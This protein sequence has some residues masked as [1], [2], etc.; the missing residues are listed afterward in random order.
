MTHHLNIYFALTRS[1][2]VRSKPRKTALL[3]SLFI[4][5]PRNVI[6]TYAIVYGIA[7][8]AANPISPTANA[9]SI[10]LATRS[11][12]DIGFAFLARGSDTPEFP[13]ASRLGLIGK[14][15]AQKMAFALD[16]FCRQNGVRVMLI[17]GPQ[18]WKSPKTGAPYMRICE[19]VLNTP[20]RTGVI[21][22]VRPLTSL[23]FIAFSINLFH[24]LRLTY[25]WNLMTSNWHQYPGRYWVVESFPS[26]AW[27]L[28]GL[29]RLPARSKL[30]PRKLNQWR[31]N[32]G[33]VTGMKMPTKLTH[34]ELQAAVVLPAGRAIAERDPSRVLLSGMNPV[35]TRDGDV[36]EGWIVSP[37]VPEE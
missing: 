24:I 14:P 2:K 30:T 11:Y 1:T 8:M 29:D 7:I 9:F 28:L 34:D 16:H 12:T 31:K 26:A 19:R 15:L 37:C 25:G 20:A 32:L 10:D 3:L 18:G 22:E 23:R 33:S 27:Q 6:L 13:K 4:S 35:I 21:G 17:D 5:P 36:L